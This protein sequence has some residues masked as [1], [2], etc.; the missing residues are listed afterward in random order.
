MPTAARVHMVANKCLKHEKNTFKQYKV[1]TKWSEIKEKNTKYVSAVHEVNET[2]KTD[3]N[4]STNFY[5]VLEQ[6]ATTH[7]L[8]NCLHNIALQYSKQYIAILMAEH[9]RK[10]L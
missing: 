4:N 10:Q 8:K 5:L 1:S 3:A 9:D 2:L 6:I 7:H